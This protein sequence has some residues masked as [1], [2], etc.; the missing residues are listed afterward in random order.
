[1][2]PSREG[3]DTLSACECVSVTPQGDGA[4][5]WRRGGPR[6]EGGPPAAARVTGVR[7]RGSLYLY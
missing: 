7:S 3:R 5:G 4:C 1:M 6:P 2:G